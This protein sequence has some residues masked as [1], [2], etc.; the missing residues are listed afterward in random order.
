MPKKHSHPDPPARPLAV[1]ILAAGK[2]TRLKNRRPKVLQP[3]CS[4]P[5]VEYVIAAVRTLDPQEVR[6]IV[7][8][9]APEV[10]AALGETMEY[11]HQRSQKGTAHAVL[12]CRGAYRKF[13]GDLLV[14]CADQP[15][16]R[17]ETFGRMLEEHRRT[18]A[19]ATVLT[20]QPENPFGYGRIRRG[21]TGRV[22]GIVEEKDCTAAQRKIHEVNVSTYVFR[23][24]DLFSALERVG[25][26]NAQGEYYLTDV[27]GILSAARKSIATVPTA[28]PGETDQVS[29]QVDLARLTA[30]VRDDILRTHMANGVTIIDPPSTFIGPEV[31]IE[32]DT[33]V[34]PNTQVE[35]ATHIGQGAVVGPNTYIDESEIG[36]GTV[37]VMSYLSH[38]VVKSDARIGPFA[39]I[40]PDSV[41]GREA[42]VGNF[43][44]VKKSVLSDGV[45]ASHLTYI[46][47]ATIGANTNVGCGT[48]TANYDGVRK[49][50]THIGADCHVG[51]GTIFIAPVHVGNDV[52]T[53]AGAV[54]TRDQEVPD[55]MT[56]V[57]VPAKMLPRGNAG[58][59]PS[60]KRTKS[61]G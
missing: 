18:G 32:A 43:V 28:F 33:I 41:I 52:T 12:Q 30:L 29:D 60:R 7:G 11:T 19:A 42:R 3:I 10:K 21:K 55:H 38:A 20:D 9:G 50:Q 22:L 8:H 27:I 53:G 56:L 54:V 1:I 14:V 24:E 6:L 25:N 58:A 47:D 16:I 39:H 36:A 59:A 51:S 45:K 34:Y 35:G 57:G 46:G 5:M 13:A 48:I 40:R 23:A 17:P 31:R 26:E 2:G 15:R 49:H 37:V 4:R 61:R 44:E